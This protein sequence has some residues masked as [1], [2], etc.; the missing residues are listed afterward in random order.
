M[1]SSSTLENM[2]AID[3]A[4]NNRQWDVYASFLSDDL[5]AFSTSEAGHHDKHAH[6]SRA[7]AFCTVYP[8]A[9]V[10]LDPYLELF[11]SADETRTC[12][13]ARITGTRGGMP[14]DTTFT[15]ISTWRG[16]R[17]IRQHQFVDEDTMSRQLRKIAGRRAPA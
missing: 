12:S 7:M 6:V 9:K 1:T 2:H 8:D 11:A 16:G 4:W 15:A 17:I 10:I 3:I 14:F 13:V 5:I